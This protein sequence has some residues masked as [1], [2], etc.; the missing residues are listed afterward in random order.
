[1]AEGVDPEDKTEDPSQKKLDDAQK[2]GDVVKSQEVPSFFVMFVATL[3]ILIGG[4]G[5]SK[6]LATSLKG[7]FAN[8]HLLSTEGDALRALM[9]HVGTIFA[10][11]TLPFV[12]AI[13]VAAVAGHLVQHPMVW[14]M[15]GLAPKFSKISPMAGLKRM[16]SSESIANFGKGL[17]KIIVVGAAAWMTLWPERDKLDLMMSADIASLSPMMLDLIRKLMI[18]V[19]SVMF[20][21]AGLDYAYQRHKWMQRQRMSVQERKEEHKQSEGNP[22]IKAKVRQLRR[23]RSRKRMMAEVPNSTVVI[24]NPTHYA[25]ALKYEMGMEAPICVAKGVDAVAFRIRQ[26]AEEA[27]V[28]IVENP[29]LARALHASVEIEDVVPPEH[30]KAVAQVIGYVLNLKNKRGWRGS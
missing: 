8:V 14:S 28:T 13:A 12:L 11:A 20:L 4:P 29:P 17:L 22:E 30:F 7:I 24:T 10:I 23:E 18:A 9:L 1:M 5:L 15:E 25:V 2:K 6:T 3:F 26:V 21:I 16:F 19:L 27:G